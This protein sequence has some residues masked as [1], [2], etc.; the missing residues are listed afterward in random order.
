MAQDA[1]KLVENSENLVKMSAPELTVILVA[2]L[3]VG[4]RANIGIAKGKPHGP[5]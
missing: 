2:I 1:K 4:Y 3:D 5:S